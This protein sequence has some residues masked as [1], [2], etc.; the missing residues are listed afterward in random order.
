[1]FGII[2]L[3]SIPKDRFYLYR[4]LWNKVEP[5][6]HVLPHWNWKGF[7]GKDIPVFVYTSYPEA[8]LFVNGVS[9]G[10]RRKSPT[11]KAQ[12]LQNENHEARYRLMWHDVKYEPGEL[13]VVA[14]DPEGKKA[15]EKVVRTAG[16]PHHIEVVNGREFIGE[17][18]LPVLQADGKDL[19]YLTVKVV[20]K[21]G[22]LCP[23]YS[24]KLEFEV[25]GAALYR[26]AANGDP[27]CLDIFHH[28]CMHAF[29]GMLTIIV[30]ASEIPGT[31]KVTVKG[32]NLCSSE[33]L[34]Q[35]AAAP[36]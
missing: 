26:A 17:T 12:G 2:D 7:E 31:A 9:Q 11:P 36:K 8:E 32:P 22:N 1:M 24:G 23:D 15:A 29:G 3:A 21:D 35:V 14:Y 18:I 34:L 33:T 10:R 5:T 25:S 28:P 13:K 19:A 4:S 16:R 27:T 30:Q 6:L 20:D